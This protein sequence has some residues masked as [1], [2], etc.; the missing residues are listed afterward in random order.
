M[1]DENHSRK[2]VHPAQSI[3]LLI[4]LLTLVSIG[5]FHS[6]PPTP[7]T[8]SAPLSE[9]SSA[10]AISHVGQIAAKSHPA[11][12]LE[13]AEVRQYLV[14]QVQGLGFKPDIQSTL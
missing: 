7:S 4:G 6:F 14:D 9:F 13:H 1:L 10:R 11:G 3:I 8:L 12:S 5:L 2:H